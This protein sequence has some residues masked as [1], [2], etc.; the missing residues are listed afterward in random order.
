M[1]NNLAICLNAPKYVVELSLTLKPISAS[2]V[3]TTFDEK[4]L[5]N[6]LGIVTIVYM[7]PEIWGREWF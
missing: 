4:L 7:C 2:N 1:I 3:L 6:N 5:S